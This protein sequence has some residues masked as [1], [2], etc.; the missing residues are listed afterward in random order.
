MDRPEQHSRTLQFTPPRELHPVERAALAAAI[1][2]YVERWPVLVEQLESARVKEWW[3]SGAG[4]YTSLAVP[5]SVQVVGDEAGKPLEHFILRMS[6]AELSGGRL[7]HGATTMGY[8]E[9]GYL[10][11]LEIAAYDDAWDG[12]LSDVSVNG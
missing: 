6:N 10:S 3:L 8:I 1:K 11:C 5:G 12:D 9:N 2:P 7:T 4:S